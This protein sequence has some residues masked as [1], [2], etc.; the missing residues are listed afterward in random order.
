MAR[1][2]AVRRVPT[3][4]PTPVRLSTMSDFTGGL[5]TRGNAFQLAANETP[6]CLDVDL[7]IGGGFVQRKVVVPWTSSTPSVPYDNMWSFS[8]TGVEQVVAL[9]NDGKL[10]F[11]AG[12]TWGATGGGGASTR[13]FSDACEFNGDLYVTDGI[14]GQ[15][16][17][18]GTTATTLGVA[19]NETIGT[20]GAHDGNAPVA[21]LICAHMGRMFVA[22]TVESG[23]AFPNR[24]RWSHAGFP[25]D[26]RQEDFI[27]I[28][29]GR[30][31]DQITAICEFR[32]RLYIFKNEST[33]ELSGYGPGTFQVVPIAQDIGCVGPLAKVVTDVGLFTFSWPQ[34]VYLDKGTGPYPIFDKIQ[35]LIR[36]GFIPEEFSGGI[37][38]G[39]VNRNVWCAIPWQGSAVNT[40]VLVYDP[41]I[42]KHRYMR[43]LEGPWYAYSLP[44]GSFCQ[45]TSPSG[46]QYLASHSSAARVGQLEQVGDTDNWGSG[47]TSTMNSYY[48]TD[49]FDMGQE[50][51]FK[52]WRRPEFVMRQG[53]SSTIQVDVSRDYDPDNV[54]ATWFI[55]QTATATGGL[56]WDID[57]PVPSLSTHGT[58]GT[59]HHSYVVTAL[60]GSLEGAPSAEVT[61]T[62]SNATLNT[63]NYNVVTWPAVTGASSYNVYGRTLGAET[64]IANTAALTYN[65]QG[66]APG[67][68]TPP[69]TSAVGGKWDDGTGMAS[70]ETWNDNTAQ[71]ETIAYGDAMGRARSVRMK[72]TGP[73]GFSWGLDAMTLKFIAVRIRG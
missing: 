68:A 64:L 19:W 4:P 27:D 57:I 8:N 37:A 38:L 43:F 60:L 3:F 49:W 50:A 20:E 10:Y 48:V 16:R 72:F 51:M 47:T 65:D 42:W 59:T 6:D 14:I 1:R 66:A 71:G 53:T 44:I 56:V 25:E 35:T 62:T 23:T 69:V 31:G 5:N 29:V 2:S 55:E 73:S 18:D 30:D 11:S 46:L 58:T 63:S 52:R 36:D 67:V 15:C 9:G 24:I 45:Q 54:Y 39:Y 28:D 32:E 21:K 70:G 13:A 26:W 7:Q 61:I 17:W 12:T 22:S 34:G 41:W 40:R 33:Y